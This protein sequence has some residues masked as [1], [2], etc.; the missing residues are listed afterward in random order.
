M[1]R[2]LYSKP[3]KSFSARGHPGAQGTWPHGLVRVSG[4][5]SHWRWRVCVSLSG[6]GRVSLPISAV[7]FSSQVSFFLSFPGSVA[8]ATV[9]L[10]HLPALFPPGPPLPGSHLRG[11]THPSSSPWVRTR[12]V[13][14][15]CCWGV[16]G[17]CKW[18]HWAG[19]QFY[20]A[21]WHNLPRKVSAGSCSWALQP[22][23]KGAVSVC[24]QGCGTVDKILW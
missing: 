5:F 14:V 9:S 7:P 22:K 12:K 15:L 18:S 16:S 24:R 8:I 4:S 17:H 11:V 10:D 1:I 19:I 3:P 2:T 13:D 20:V 21:N 23:L 6:P